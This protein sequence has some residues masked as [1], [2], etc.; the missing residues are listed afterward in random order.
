MR[1]IDDLYP[2]IGAVSYTVYDIERV[3]FVYVRCNENIEEVF[4]AAIAQL[5]D[6]FK[7]IGKHFAS[8]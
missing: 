8:K 5:V 3:C 6:I 1:T 7:T 4:R 2:D